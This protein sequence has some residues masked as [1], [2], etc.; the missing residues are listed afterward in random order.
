MSRTEITVSHETYQEL[1]RKIID[2]GFVL[3]VNDSTDTI[4]VGDLKIH[5]DSSKQEM[6]FGVSRN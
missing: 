3:A 5:L 2:A 4:V 6:V 1:R